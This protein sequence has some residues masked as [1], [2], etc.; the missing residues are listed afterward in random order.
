M[1][2]Y[3]RLFCA[4]MLPCSGRPHDGLILLLWNPTKCPQFKFG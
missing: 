2:I 1:H 3:L 4:G